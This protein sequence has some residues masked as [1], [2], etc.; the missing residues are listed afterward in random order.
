MVQAPPT[1]AVPSALPTVR[2]KVLLRRYPNVTFL[3]RDISGYDRLAEQ[4]RI[5]L[6]T[7]IA[8]VFSRSA[9]LLAMSVA[10]LDEMY[11]EPRRRDVP[12]VPLVV[13]A[14]R[15]RRRESP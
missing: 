2:L 12:I 6:A 14:T 15:Q 10:T 9:G 13:E 1:S 4:S 11:A 7:G 8:N 5:K 3:T